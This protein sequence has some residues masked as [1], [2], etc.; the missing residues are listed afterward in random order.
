VVNGRPISIQLVH[1]DRCAQRFN[2]GIVERNPDT[3]V[4][5]GQAL[6]PIVGQLLLSVPRDDVDENIL[7]PRKVPG[8][9]PNR[10]ANPSRPM[11]NEL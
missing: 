3:P 8:E 1:V 5:D 7:E 2:L 6:A 11:S 10:V 4:G 9:S